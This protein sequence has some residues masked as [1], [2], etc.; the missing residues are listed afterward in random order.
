MSLIDL[1]EFWTPWQHLLPL[2]N[3]SRP[4]VIREQVLSKLSWITE[5]VVEQEAKNSQGSICTE[6][7]LLWLARPEQP[8]QLYGELLVALTLRRVAPHLKKNSGGIV[9]NVALRFLKLFPIRGGG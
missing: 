7:R 2:R 6:R 4:N 1:E 9:L 8:G 5:K 3:E